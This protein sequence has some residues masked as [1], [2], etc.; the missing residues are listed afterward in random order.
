MKIN[1]RFNRLIA[2]TTS[3]LSLLFITTPPTFA[4]E[5]PSCVG[6]RRIQTP[7]TY[8]LKITNNCNRSQKMR[9][10]LESGSLTGAGC[11]TISPGRT[12]RYT[13]GRTG[14]QREFQRLEKCRN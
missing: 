12:E 13:W 2:A 7:S 8:A 5:P 10:I 1:C 11:L 4:E 9:I 14:G 3:T 6:Y